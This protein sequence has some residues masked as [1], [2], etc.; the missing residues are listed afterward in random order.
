M[1]VYQGAKKLGISNKELIALIDEPQVN[2]HM[3]RI[4]EDQLEDLGLVEKKI[5]EEPPESTKTIDSAET[6]VV[7]VEVVQPAVAEKEACPY[8]IAE[9]KL[10]CR[11]CGNKSSMWKWRHLIA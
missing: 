3:D 6:D 8:T 9:I 5:I 10:G 4:P 7:E 11:G 1:Q 2:H